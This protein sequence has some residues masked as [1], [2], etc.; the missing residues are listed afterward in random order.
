MEFRYGI[1]PDS[2][3]RWLIFERVSCI[4]EERGWGVGRVVLSRI[5]D[6]EL[7]AIERAT[8]EHER[9]LQRQR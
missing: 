7:R 5:V 4:Q 8:A 9:R 1:S 2:L 6:A 3:K